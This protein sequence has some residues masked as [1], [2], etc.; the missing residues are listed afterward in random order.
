MLRINPE[1]RHMRNVNSLAYL[2]VKFCNMFHISVGIAD[3]AQSPQNP[4]K[5]ISIRAGKTI[6]IFFS[7]FSVFCFSS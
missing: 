7:E 2:I 6:Y 5:Q 3:S 4:Q 1:D